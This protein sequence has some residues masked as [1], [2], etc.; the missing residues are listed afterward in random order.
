[1]LAVT[2]ELQHVAFTCW[3]HNCFKDVFWLVEAGHQRL[4]SISTL[5]NA[6]SPEGAQDGK[7]HKQ[8]AEGS[9]TGTR[10]HG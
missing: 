1:M 7:E 10:G 9:A 4:P 8:V 5:G 6:G 3:N 2:P